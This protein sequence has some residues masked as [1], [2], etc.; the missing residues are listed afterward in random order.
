MTTTPSDGA[1]PVSHAPRRT[2]LEKWVF[3]R[4]GARDLD[5]LRAHQLTALRSTVERARRLSPFYAARLR[6][7]EPGEPTSLDGLARLPRTSADDVREQ[8]MRMLCAPASQVGRIVTLPT[9]GTTGEPKRIYFTAADQELTVDF[10][11]HGMSVPVRP[12]WRVLIL[13]PGERP[14]SVGDLLRRGLTRMDVE[15]VVHGPVSD[16]AQMLRVL[17]AGDFDCIVGIPVQVLGLARRDAASGAPVSLRS[18]LLS[19]DQA[20]RSLVAAIESTWGCR[21]FDHYGTTETGLGGGVECEAL[22][23]YHLREADLLFEVVDPDTGIPVPEGEYGE[24]VFTTL[25]REAMPLIRYQTGDRGRFLTE[26]CPCGTPLRRLGRVRARYC[27]RARLRGGGMVDQAALDEPLFAL[28]PVLDV[29]AVLRREAEA[30]VLDVEVLAP[31]AGVALLERATAALEAV[32]ALA[33]AVAS[34]GLRVEVAVTPTPW[35]QGVGTAKR[36]LVESTGT[37]EGTT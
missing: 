11:Q 7:I 27:G 30:D 15:G 19:T 36:T 22:D 35:P 31:G 16:P 4:A 25:T 17:H 33:A 10:F 8:G 5:E 32:P 34:G 1:A 37:T 9:S 29:R 2:P 13:L 6:D 18:I 12:G 21:V 24:V 20:P 14:G 23:G 28:P 26:P 3:A